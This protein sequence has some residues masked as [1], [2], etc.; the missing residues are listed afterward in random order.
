MF[1]AKNR[2]LSVALALVLVLALTVTA[3]AAWPS[4]QNDYT[5]N[6][7][8]VPG[9]YPPTAA[10]TTP[11]SV[12]LSNTGTPTSPLFSGID[13]ETV[14][15]SGSIAYTLYNGGP[16]SG[17]NGGARLQATNMANAS[18]VFN[19][20]ISPTS[21][22]AFILS[23]PYLDEASGTLYV[24]TTWNNSAYTAYGWEF[25][26]VTNLSSATPTVTQIDRGDGQAN[27]PISGYTDAGG[28]L[29]YVYFGTYS[30]TSTVRQMG[31]Y[32]Q[33]P[34]GG[35]TPIVFTPRDDFYWA[36]A[37]FITV[38][39]VDYVVFG[40]DNSIIY[41]NPIGAS[42][43]TPVNALSLSNIGTNAPGAVRSSISQT[44][45]QA[46]FVFF[47]S[48]GTSAGILWQVAFADLLNASS[49]SNGVT[50]RG[51]GSTTSTPVISD[52]GVVYVG[53]YYNDPQTFLSV[54]G[55]VEVYSASISAT[56][57]PS[58]LATVYSGAD[59]VQSSI[60]VCSEIDFLKDYIY[61]TTNVDHSLDPTP[62][63]NH[64]GYCYSYDIPSRGSA[65]IWNPYSG[66]SNAL[67]GFAYDSNTGR[68]IYGDDSDTLYIF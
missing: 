10:G 9:V 63:V 1:K 4:F 36:G 45:T 59:G 24:A 57:P 39:G 38:R 13:T 25:W 65:Q 17:T 47:T 51:R 66:G 12:T 31:T 32:R 21:D 22:N 48:Q 18:M 26:R 61:F 3:F 7:L 53:T 23:T 58:Y 62:S 15:S 2:L 40:S 55:T 33:Y 42:F 54:S 56:A 11:T 34:A 35:G 68:I 19:I 20:Q 27:T 43:A 64:N 49:T 16:T 14:I 5:N 60:I 6:G 44:P 67:Q 52:W 8:I 37:T 30:V 28:R 50:L 46:E 29:Q 41:V